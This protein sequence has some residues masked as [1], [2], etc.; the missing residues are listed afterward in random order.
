MLTVHTDS[1]FMKEAL[2]EAE[3]AYD[4][5]EIP[6]GAVVVFNNRIIARAHNQVEML[7]DVTAHAE[8]LAITAAANYMGG[9]FLDGCKLFVTLEPCPMCAGAIFWS[10]PQT[11]V[12]GAPDA[13]RG[14][15]RMHPNMLHPAT[16]VV[17]G[18]L[19]T[20]CGALVSR[21]FDQLRRK[22]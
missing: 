15:Q 6:V 22:G 11:L 14:Y 21:F 13:N 5:A 1:F 3:K 4:A 7:T 20:E 16:K 8:M 12:F 2:K 19:Q 17:A 9:K 18:V 10:R